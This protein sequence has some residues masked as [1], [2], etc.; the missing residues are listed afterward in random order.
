MQ[1]LSPVGLEGKGLLTGGYS[2]FLPAVD[3]TGVAGCGP[4]SSLSCAPMSLLE[5]PLPD[6]LFLWPPAALPPAR[7]G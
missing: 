7:E 6:S 4:I 1:L 2:H 5:H 3:P